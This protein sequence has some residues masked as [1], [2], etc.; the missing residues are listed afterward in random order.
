[1]EQL[2]EMGLNPE[3]LFGRRRRALGGFVAMIVGPFE[4]EVG[5]ACVASRFTALRAD[6]GRLCLCR[7]V[8]DA[9]R[10]HLGLQGGQ[11]SRREGRYGPSYTEEMI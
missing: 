1:M 2:V 9:V 10:S 6:N 11:E 4:S 7:S 5:G 8:L 3:D